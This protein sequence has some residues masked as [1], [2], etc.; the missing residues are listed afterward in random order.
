MKIKYGTSE[1]TTSCK[2]KIPLHLYE[3]TFFKKE[4]K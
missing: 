2:N 3:V 1:K 4:A